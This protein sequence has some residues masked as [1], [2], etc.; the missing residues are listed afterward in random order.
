MASSDLESEEDD[1]CREP[2]LPVADFDDFDPSKPPLTGEEYLR[3][4]QLEANKCPAIVVADI[5]S[6]NY[7]ENRSC[8]LSDSFQS[9][10][11]HKMFPLH[12]QELVS[13]DFHQ[14]QERLDKIRHD[15]M[16]ECSSRKRKLPP[17]CDHE[18]WKTLCLGN[19]DESDVKKC[20][21]HD[22][23]SQGIQS[24]YNSPNDRALLAMSQ[25]DLLRL[26]EYQ[27][28]W[29]SQYGF[30]EQNALWTYSI[31]SCLQSPLNGD[32]Y[33]LLRDIARAIIKQIYFHDNL[34]E[35]SISSNLIICIIARCFNQRDLIENS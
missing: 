32:T 3:R 10:H 34:P 11:C 16:D 14:L 18:A 12:I 26:L 29:I 25:E 21:T 35:S 13:D 5:E 31:L 30:H 7:D 20:D 27:L 6:S 8:S 28:Q 4:V 1:L 9:T 33:S 17:V 24:K 19:L 22:G 2:V 23:V 15:A